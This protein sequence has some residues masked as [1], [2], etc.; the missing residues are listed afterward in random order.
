MA[1]KL[2]PF[3]FVSYASFWTSD[4]FTARREV[5]RTSKCWQKMA[6]FLNLKRSRHKCR[7]IRMKRRLPNALTTILLATVENITAV[8]SAMGRT[9]GLCDIANQLEDI[10]H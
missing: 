4:R 9:K 5:P 3:N 1:C 6:G 7:C 10:S 2:G 8:C